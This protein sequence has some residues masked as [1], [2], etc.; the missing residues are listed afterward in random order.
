MGALPLFNIGLR[1]YS[2]HANNVT[3]MS[4]QTLHTQMHLSELVPGKTGAV[5]KGIIQNPEIEQL[6]SDW[7]L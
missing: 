5:A 3:S 4:P 1:Q 2:L 6:E 7:L